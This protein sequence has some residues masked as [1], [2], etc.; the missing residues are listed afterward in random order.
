MSEAIVQQAVEFAWRQWT[1]LGVAGVA[2]IPEHAIDLEA[3]LAFTPF[4]AAADPRLAAEAL[5]WCVRIGPRFVSR[6]RLKQLVALMPAPQV[7]DHQRLDLALAAVAARR[8]RPDIS[9]KSRD[10]RM[11]LAVTIGLRS[12]QVFGVG[13]RAD[14]IAA[15]VMRPRVEPCTL[16][17]LGV[18]GYTRPALAAALDDLASV[19]VVTKQA[20]TRALFLL[21]K[22]DPLRALLAP[23]PRPPPA[24]VHRL[25]LIATALDV[26]RRLGARRTYAVELAKELDRLA[27]RLRPL[28]PDESPP[29]VGRPPDLLAAVDNWAMPLLAP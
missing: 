14:V 20:G 11:D 17:Q 4:V 15:L 29:L 25:A 27:V 3:L 23:V 19:G 24:W 6:S 26:W 12:R 22:R 1:A 13:A 5:D 21:R 16:T 2:P 9:G 8:P 18:L 7:P 28:G 10:P